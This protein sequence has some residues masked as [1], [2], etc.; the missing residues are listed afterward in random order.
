MKKL[1]LFVLVVGSCLLLSLATDR[2]S[3][4]TI[5]YVKNGELHTETFDSYDAYRVR[6]HDLVKD[7]VKVY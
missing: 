4:Y 2:C 1:L 6:Y 5:Q 3:N 7:N